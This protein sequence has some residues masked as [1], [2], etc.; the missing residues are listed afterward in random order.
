M[1]ISTNYKRGHF[2][3]NKSTMHCFSRLFV[4]TSNFPTYK[5]EKFTEK[6][7]L[8]GAALADCLATQLSHHCKGIFHRKLVYHVLLL[9]TASSHLQPTVFKVV[10][11]K[12]TGSAPL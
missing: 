9:S 3:E 8:L 1:G 12:T 4:A 7:S 2:I 10:A 5:K 6:I 11:C